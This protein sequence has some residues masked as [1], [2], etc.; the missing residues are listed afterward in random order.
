MHDDD[1]PVDSP[2][3]D[4]WLAIVK[5]MREQIRLRIPEMAAMN[6]GEITS[7]VSAAQG[8]AWL[9]QHVATFDKRIAADKAKSFFD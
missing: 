3:Q 1:E 7:M 6:P 9:S 4:E 2:D 8:L 5:G